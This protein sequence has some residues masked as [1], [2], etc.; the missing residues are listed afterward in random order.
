MNVMIKEVCDFTLYD[1]NDDGSIG[2]PA[3]YL[4]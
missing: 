2:A 4:D 1:I 3:L